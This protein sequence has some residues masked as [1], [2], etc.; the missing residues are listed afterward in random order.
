MIF[1]TK[2]INT[3]P[4]TLKFVFTILMLILLASFSVKLSSLW[5]C[6]VSMPDNIPVNV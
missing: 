4:M 6:C 2:V 1:L 3:F 5:H